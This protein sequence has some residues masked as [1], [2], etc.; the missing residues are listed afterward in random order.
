MKTEYIRI[1]AWN[2]GPLA[3]FAWTGLFS[4]K[5]HDCWLP[6]SVESK[7]AVSKWRY[8]TNSGSHHGVY[9]DWWPQGS[10]GSPKSSSFVGKHLRFHGLIMWSHIHTRWFYWFMPITTIAVLCCD[11]SSGSPQHV[12][13]H[14]SVTLKDIQLNSYSSPNRG[15][16][17]YGTLWHE[18]IVYTGAL[19]Q[20][21]SKSGHV[22]SIQIISGYFG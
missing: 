14:C 3:L 22:L 17:K 8:I 4:G 1:Y 20:D 21:I 10:P 12:A 7:P 2:Y 6:M 13:R 18:T 9:G 11:D 5:Y 15:A 16:P 19:I